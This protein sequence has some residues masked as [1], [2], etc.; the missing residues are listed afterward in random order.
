MSGNQKTFYEYEEITNERLITHIKNTSS[1]HRF[2]KEDWG[3]LKARQYCGILN[4]D[5][6]DFYI[7]PKIANH[8]NDT[9]LT[10]FIYMLK[11]VYDIKIS[12]EHISNSKNEKSDN[13]LEIF[14]QLFAKNLFREF[15]KGV[16]KEYVTKQDNLRVLRGKYL[17]NE[18]LKHNFTNDK[19]YCEYDEFQEDNPLNQFFLY[20]IKTLMKFANDKKLLKQCELVLDGVEYKQIKTETLNIHF[21]RLNQRFKDSFEFALLLLSKSI[22]M[23]EKDKKSFAFL[24]D[25]NELFESFV[26]KLYKEIDTNTKVQHIKYFGNLKLIPDIYTSDLIIDVKYKL[27]KNK[28]DLKRDDKYQMFVYGTNFEVKNTMLLYPKHLEDVNEDL[29]LGKDDKMV[30]LKMRSVDLDFVDDGYEEYIEE[31]KERLENL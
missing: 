28:E 5:G 21:N 26:S 17:I 30:N 23:F 4:Y 31:I 19:V 25:M 1:L 15:K 2:F 20:A 16:Y 7:L 22:P 6:D 18:N 9:N 29:E 13:I 10:I 14:I 3:K 24:F 27:A 8:D 11:Y 12:N